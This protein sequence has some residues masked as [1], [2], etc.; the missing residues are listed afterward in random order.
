MQ[1][2]YTQVMGE[3]LDLSHGSKNKNHSSMLTLAL[4]YKVLGEERT[5]YIEIYYWRENGTKKL[6]DNVCE[7]FEYQMY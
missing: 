1:T 4:Y 7:R 2:N 5:R 6:F 3:M